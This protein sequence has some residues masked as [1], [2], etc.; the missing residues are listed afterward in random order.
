MFYYAK[1]TNMLYYRENIDL[2][3]DDT[4]EGDWEFIKNA[5]ING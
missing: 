4:G 5:F 3:D 2:T 1:N